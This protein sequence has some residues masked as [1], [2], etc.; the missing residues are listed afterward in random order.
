MRVWQC[1]YRYGNP[2]AEWETLGP[3]K[4]EIFWLQMEYRQITIDKTTKI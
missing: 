4:P 1:R 2:N 3:K